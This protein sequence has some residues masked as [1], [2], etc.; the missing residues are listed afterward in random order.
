MNLKLGN[1]G[2]VAL[3]LFISFSIKHEANRSRQINA[4]GT[5]ETPKV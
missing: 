3:C 5:W 1:P 4:C 2:V